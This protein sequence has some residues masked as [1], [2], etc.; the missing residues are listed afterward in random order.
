MGTRKS[1]ARSQSVSD[2]K[3]DRKFLGGR[4]RDASPS[5][6][7]DDQLKLSECQS[8]LREPASRVGRAIML[9]ADND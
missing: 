4:H 6:E 5:R 3:L 7:F 8:E 9:G 1:I 2:G